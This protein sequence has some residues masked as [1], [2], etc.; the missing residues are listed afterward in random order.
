MIMLFSS[1]L[2]AFVCKTNEGQEVGGGTQSINDVPIDNDIFAV[3][4]RINEFADVSDF[5][6][7]RN[8]APSSY[9]D[10]LNVTGADLGPTFKNN[11]ELKAGVVIR[12]NYYLAPFSGR[13][14]SVFR[15]TSATERL[16][17][18]LYLQVNTK[19]TPSVLVRKGDLLMTLNLHK[20]AT[21]VGSNNQIDHAYFTWNFYAG[22]DVIVGTGTCDINN[23][24]III[25]DFE[26]VN[27]SGI[28]TVGSASRFQRNV[29]IS[30]RCEDNNLTTPIK[31]TLSGDTSTFSSDALLVRTGDIGSSGAIMPGLGVEIYRQG[32]RISPMNGSFN[33]QITNGQGK[34]TLM[35]ALVKKQNLAKTDL[36]EGQFN[37]AATIIMSTP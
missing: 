5:M 16:Q 28:S 25:V 26:T 1:P 27:A 12:G 3:P 30:Y 10:Y 4:N 15:L 17:I 20:Y 8:E 29:E 7:C 35:F 32:G 31:M 9:V 11:P 6:S 18:K 36:I 33:S 22:N 14:I 19:P 23:N 13:E 24:Q 37:S 2:Y 21:F 34:D